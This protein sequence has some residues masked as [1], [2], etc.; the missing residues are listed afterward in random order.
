M[1]AIAKDLV[2]TNGKLRSDLLM[3]MTGPLP[4][5]TF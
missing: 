5:T 3:S 1:T 4:S 2:P